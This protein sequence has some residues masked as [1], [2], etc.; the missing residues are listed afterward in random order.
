MTE[1]IGVGAVALAESATVDVDGLALWL[2]VSVPAAAPA[3]VGANAIAAVQLAPG[4]S[5]TPA[6]QLPPETTKPELAV[7]APRTSGAV[8]VLASVALCAALVAPTSVDANTRAPGLA[9][10]L[11]A[12]AAS[13][14]PASETTVV[15]GVALCENVS[16]P[17]AAPVVAGRNDTVTVQ[18]VP[19][20]TVAP[21]LH[22]PPATTNVPLAANEI[23]PSAAVPLLASVT[24]CAALVAP[25]VVDAKVTLAGA[26]LA[27]GVL[28]APGLPR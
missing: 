17:L 13:P 28:A 16:V 20:A 10:A 7:T 5:D 19:A 25:T 27:T 24:V 23:G 1:A 21:A 6:A 15:V 26:A 8:P 12:A 14:V 18:L 2:K 9:A 22:V 3:T 4:A 11:G